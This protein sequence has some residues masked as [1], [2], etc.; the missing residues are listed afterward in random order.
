LRTAA[1]Y[2]DEAR[3]EAASV[4]AACASGLLSEAHDRDL[5]LH[6]IGTHHGCGRPFFPVWDDEP[7]FTVLV[8]A[9]GKSFET[10]SGKELARIDSGWVD[11]FARLN[12][13]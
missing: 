12:R 8:E 13:R 2:P 11:R 1:G 4:M 9:D 7:G 5:V 6:L 3:H 10:S